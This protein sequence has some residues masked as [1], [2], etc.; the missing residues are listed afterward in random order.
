MVEWLSQGFSILCTIACWVFMVGVY[1]TK[2]KQHDKELE[3]IKNKQD[4]IDKLLISINKT[5]AEL[6]TKVQ[7]LI[8]DKIKK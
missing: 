7:L 4:C 1:V 6:N 5:L 2:I 8:D 3:E